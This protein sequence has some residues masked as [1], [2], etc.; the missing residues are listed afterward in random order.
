ME[1][2]KKKKTQTMIKQVRTSPRVC[3]TLY[4]SLMSAA[5]E[6]QTQEVT[7]GYRIL[8][9]KDFHNLYYSL[10]IFKEDITWKTLA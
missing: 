6:P 2:N 7:G 10:N 1:K 9:D 8:C 3:G 5:F 4:C